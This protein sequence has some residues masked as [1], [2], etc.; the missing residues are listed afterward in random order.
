METRGRSATLD[1]H[2]TATELGRDR[3]MRRVVPIGALLAPKPNSREETLDRQR[4]TA[5]Q[6]KGVQ[7]LHRQ[8]YSYALFIP[9]TLGEREPWS[10]QTTGRFEVGASKRRRMKDLVT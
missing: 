5:S 3:D 6:K 10:I 1:A 4:R 2:S 8:A 9:R 7:N